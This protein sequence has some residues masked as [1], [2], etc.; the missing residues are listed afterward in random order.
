LPW[1]AT[2]KRCPSCLARHRYKGK[3]PPEFFEAPVGGP[4]EPEESPSATAGGAARQKEPPRP[5][6]AQPPSEIPA[7]ARV[8]R[9]RQRPCTQGWRVAAGGLALLALASFIAAAGSPSSGA[10]LIAG[11]VL[12][13][14]AFGVVR[15]GGVS[16]SIAL[17]L[18]LLVLTVQMGLLLG[19]APQQAAAGTL[20]GL[21][22]TLGLVAA[23]IGLLTL[24]HGRNDSVIAGAIMLG[25]GLLFLLLSPGL[26]SAG[27]PAWPA[28]SSSL[29]SEVGRMLPHVGNAPAP[30][31]TVAPATPRAFEIPE[32]AKN[33]SPPPRP[34]YTPPPQP[35]LPPMTMLPAVEPAAPA[36][37]PPPVIPPAAPTL[38]AVESPAA[39]APAQLVEKIADWKGTLAARGIR[40]EFPDVLSLIAT[41]SRQEVGQRMLAIQRYA[42]DNPTIHCLAIVF[43]GVGATP[44]A[45]APALASTHPAAVPSVSPED[46][47][48]LAHLVA[49]EVGLPLKYEMWRTELNPLVYYIRLSGPR[50]GQDWQ[51]RIE[52]RAVGPDVLVLV[53]QHRP[54]DGAAQS[55]AWN[56]FR[57][58]Q[59]R[60][61]RR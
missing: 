37:S 38:P 19:Y 60:T 61:P 50:D 15:G 29:Q 20:L 47:Q 4:G 58:L 24:Q 12:L 5:Y 13:I 51:V 43:E 52:S 44:A 42:V 49:G 57:S 31:P 34:A 7:N 22:F 3:V 6:Y 25:A 56:F 9:W 17:V 46:L 18:P 21:A 23:G 11:A 26:L 1:P 32:W 35:G 14:L 41:R 55:A 33:D 16:R 40:L 10:W 45:S 59:V 36:P 2:E 8:A 39:S 30:A 28:I 54:S 53:S 27:D 48:N